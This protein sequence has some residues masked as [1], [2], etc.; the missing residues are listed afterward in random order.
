LFYPVT[1][2]PNSII[3]RFNDEF[4]HYTFR[5]NYTDPH[6]QQETQN[7]IHTIW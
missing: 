2:Q 3:H 7:M 5:H 6:T 1:L 4:L